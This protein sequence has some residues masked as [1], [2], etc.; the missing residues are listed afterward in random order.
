MKKLI[1]LT[2]AT[3]AGKTTVEKELNKLGIPS[4]VSYTTRP[5][6][7]GEINEVD[8]HF[9]TNEKLEEMESLLIE[10]MEFSGYYY[11][12]TLMALGNAFINSDIAV[13]VVEPTGVK[14]FKDY[15]AAEPDLEIIPIYLD[16]DYEVIVKRL[17]GRYLNDFAGEDK[18]AYYWNRLVQQYNEHQTWPRYTSWRLHFDQVNESIDGKTPED[19]ARRILDYLTA[20]AV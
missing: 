14:L 16:S 9:Y 11:G 7:A 4:I 13:I 12:S 19:I 10:K 20:R 1:L 8:Y 18:G 15:A 3:C 17:I 6:R 2:G 5:P